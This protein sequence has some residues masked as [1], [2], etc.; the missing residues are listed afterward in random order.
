LLSTFSSIV[1]VLTLLATAGR[2]CKVGVGLVV[3]FPLLGVSMTFWIGTEPILGR[4]ESLEGELGRIER[5]RWG[6]WT[7][8]LQLI[9][10]RPLLGTGCA[11]T[12]LGPWHSI[13]RL[14][15][16]ACACA[17]CVSLA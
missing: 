6:I 10:Q 16:M 1:V 9:R 8:T 4:F 11:L 3:I 13:N 15:N 12:C 7:D 14:S 2:L 5:G 17:E